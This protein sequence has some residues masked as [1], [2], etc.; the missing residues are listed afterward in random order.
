MRDRYWKAIERSYRREDLVF[1]ILFAIVGVLVAILVVITVILAFD[2]IDSAGI[3]PNKT[4]VVV[5]E[6][7]QIVPAHTTSGSMW[8]GRTAIPTMTHHPESYQIGR[9]HV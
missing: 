3:T 1:K 8:V 5:V 7:K 4:A 2:A 6:E 9:A